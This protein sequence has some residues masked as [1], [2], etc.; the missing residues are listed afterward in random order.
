MKNL[1]RLSLA[2]MKEFVTTHNARSDAAHPA[3]ESNASFRLIA[4]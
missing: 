2:E 4:I 1:E 3:L